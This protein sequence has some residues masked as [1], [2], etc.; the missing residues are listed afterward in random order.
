[1]W[2]ATVRAAAITALAGVFAH[3]LYAH[4]RRVPRQ[5]R[6]EQG[7]EQDMR[8]ALPLAAA[9]ALAILPPLSAAASP[10]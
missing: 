6:D 3:L 10:L 1:L 2:A 8:G 7:D 5:G 4:D 9:T